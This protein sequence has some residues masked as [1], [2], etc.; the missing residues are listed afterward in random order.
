[1]KKRRCFLIFL[2][3]LQISA[4]R[5]RT[6]T[7][8][9]APEVV[10]EQPTKPDN[11]D[12]LQALQG[13]WKSESDSTYVLV[14]AEAK[15]RHLINGQLQAETEIEVDGSCSNISCQGADAADGWCFLE[16]GQFDIQ[17]LLILKCNTDELQYAAVGAENGNMSFKKVR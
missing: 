4:C 7:Q 15:M 14:I 1:M 17:C 10:N 16:K 13:T 3:V 12:L 11:N 9:S 2:A 5:N 8:T 6:Q